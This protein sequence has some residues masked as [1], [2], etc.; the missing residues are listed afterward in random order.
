MTRM[1]DT[2]HLH[3]IAISDAQSARGTV[4]RPAQNSP[5]V[6]HKYAEL[7][8]QIEREAQAARSGR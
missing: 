2:S 4:L 1:P 5:E 7:L 6:V 8:A 3:D